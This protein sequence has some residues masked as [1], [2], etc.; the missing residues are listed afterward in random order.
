MTAMMLAA[1]Q[2]TG[3]PNSQMAAG[4]VDPNQLRKMQAAQAASFA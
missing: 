4:G 2:V 3:A 1:N